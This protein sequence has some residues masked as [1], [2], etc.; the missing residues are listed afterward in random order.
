MNKSEV[1][2]AFGT[3][4]RS[5]RNRLG[6]S[7]EQLAERASLHRTYISD[8]ERAARNLS[9]ES[10]SKLAEALEVSVAALFTPTVTPNHGT[11]DVQGHNGDQEVVDILLVED[12]E[13]DVALTLHAFKKSRFANRVQVV[14]DGMEALDYVF[15]R[16]AYSDRRLEDYPRIILLD[17]NLPKISGLEV[18]RL[19]KADDKTRMIPV[20]VLTASQSDRDIAESRRLGAATYIV[21]PIDFHRL[22]QVTPQL[23]LNWVLLKPTEALT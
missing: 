16:G 18:L 22:S 19:I 12:D 7:Q 23:S 11:G 5:R 4:I 17:L 8:I 10:I 13:N 20:V 6:L 9:L 1:K 15:C 3:A 14:A 21:K 2:T